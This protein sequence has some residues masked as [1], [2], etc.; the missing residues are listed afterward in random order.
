MVQVCN[1]MINWIKYIHARTT[2]WL[3]L[4]AQEINKL[5]IIKLTNIQ[6]F[7]IILKEMILQY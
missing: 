4:E 7:C 5:L 1:L 2:K 6:S 3:S